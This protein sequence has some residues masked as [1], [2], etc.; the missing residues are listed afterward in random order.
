[1]GQA[2]FQAAAAAV[3]SLEVVRAPAD[4]GTRVAGYLIDVLPAIVLGLFGLIPIMGAIIAGLLLAPYWLLRDVTGS[5]LGKLILR[6][7]VVRKDGQPASVRARILRNVPLAI[8]PAFLIIPLLGYF[9]GPATA[10]IAVL[11]EGIMLLTQGERI[12]DRI[13]GT[14]VIKK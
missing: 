13:A 6:T 8:G 3:P 10:G 9:L 2:G 11:V 4:K 1:M 7:M 14:T 5:S 12:G